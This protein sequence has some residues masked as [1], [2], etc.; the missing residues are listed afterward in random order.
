V[1]EAALTLLASV[2]GDDRVI[3]FLLLRADDIIPS[4]RDAA[5]AAVAPRLAPESAPALARSLRLVTLLAGRTR[6]ARCGVSAAISALLTRPACRT[7]LVRASERDDDPAARLAAF[8]LRLGVEPIPVVVASALRDRET[9]VQAW[10][11]RV[12]TA[13]T[14]SEADRRAL[15][16]ALAASPSPMT[17]LL[18]LRSAARLDPHDDAPLERAV[19]DPQS[20]VRYA[21]HTSLRARRPDRPFGA[22]REVALAVLAD[23]AAPRARLVGALGSLSDVGLAA[24]LPAIARFLGDARASVRRE[25]SRTHEVLIARA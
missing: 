17:R 3:P 20:V 23:E 22:A 6:G 14:T 1:R 9:S 19:L 18:G 10:A 11:A 25:A 7:V 2:T 5:E 24:D 16:H 21:A 4:I 15:L 12:A 13:N 8:E